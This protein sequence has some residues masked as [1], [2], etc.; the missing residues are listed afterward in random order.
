MTAFPP[1]RPGS[2]G[3]FRF[4]GRV[5]ARRRGC[6]IWKSSGWRSGWGAQNNH[7]NRFQVASRVN[8]S[9]RDAIYGRRSSSLNSSR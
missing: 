6:P 7:W 9:P 4:S 5:P 1:W 2:G 3:R 8:R